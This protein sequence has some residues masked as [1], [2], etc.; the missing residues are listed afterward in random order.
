MGNKE[1]GKKEEKLAET[2]P[3]NMCV[4][5]AKHETKEVLL[6]TI[7]ESSVSVTM[8]GRKP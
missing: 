2:K 7:G 8:F 5:G 6:G 3:K 4:L 1:K